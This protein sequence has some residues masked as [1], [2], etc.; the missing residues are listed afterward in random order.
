M[1][2]V[3]QQLHEPSPPSIFMVTLISA[4]FESCVQ[5]ISLHLERPCIASWAYAESLWFVRATGVTLKP[6][7]KTNHT[8]H[9]T[10]GRMFQVK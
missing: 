5:L 3:K 8:L 1:Y 10:D 9:A 6:V 2:V 4:A 7:K